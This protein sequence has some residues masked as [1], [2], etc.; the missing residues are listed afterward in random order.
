[1]KNKKIIPLLC[2]IIGIALVLF[3]I[4]GKDYKMF[5][6]YKS[7]FGVM[8]GIGSGLFGGGLGQ[9]INISVINKYP[10]IKKKKDIEMNDERNIHINNMAKA[11]AFDMMGFIFPAIILGFVLAEFDF[12]IIIVLLIT[13]LFI[14]AI[15]IYYLSKYTKEM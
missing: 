11:K 2:I 14:Y 13:Y 7:L 12:V 8:I 10:D 5:D 6:D 15:Q 4:V 9:L 3:C 1:M